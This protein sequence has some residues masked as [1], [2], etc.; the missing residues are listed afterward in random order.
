[1]KMMLEDSS[2]TFDEL[3]GYKLST[4]LEFADR[5]LDDLFTAVDHYGSQKAKEARAVLEE[6]DRE[7]NTDSR[8]TLLFYLW[9]SRF[10]INDPAN[11]SVKWNREHPDTTPDGFSDPLRA[12]QLLEA[13]VDEMQAR[14]GRLDVPWGDFYRLRQNGRDFPANG[15]TEGLGVF[16]VAHSYDSRD[17][18]QMYVGSG[19]SWVG[20]IE[21][22]ENIK[23]NVLLSYGNATQNNS[24]HNGD[25]LELFSKKE[26]REAWF[27]PEQVKKHTVRTEVFTQKG[28]EE[29]LHKR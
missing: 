17:G 8:G 28:V 5:M 3:V 15:A 2:I 21:F 24:P 10:N 16:R 27:T 4:R 26:L 18:K 25:Q 13:T 23:A 22:G 12:V 1:V 9:A 19:D 7:A 29:Y 14:F 11:Y 20:I 6:W